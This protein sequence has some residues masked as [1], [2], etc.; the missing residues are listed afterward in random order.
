[1]QGTL[2]QARLPNPYYSSL[3]GSRG[4]SR[5]LTFE[6]LSPA[7]NL[8]YIKKN[9]WNPDDPSITFPGTR[10]ARAR[11]PEG[12]FS[13]TSFTPASTSSVPAPIPAPSIHNL[14]QHW[15]I[16]SME[17]FMAQPEA[18]AQPEVTSEATPQTSPATTPFVEVSEEEEG[19][20]ETDYATNMAAA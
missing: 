18:E 7:I 4:S 11:G 2:L 10:K 12:P 8:A 5:P 14:A 6:S 13:S 15:P 20:E 1:M 9:C 17:D 3:H 19:A 16:I